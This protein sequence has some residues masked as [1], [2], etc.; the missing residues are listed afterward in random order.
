MKK[1]INKK[2]ENI[3]LDEETKKDEKKKPTAKK[4]VFATILILLAVVFV[5]LGFCLCL[6]AFD[7]LPAPCNVANAFV[8]RDS[9]GVISNQFY[10]GITF[11][12]YTVEDLNNLYGFFIN[13]NFDYNPDTCPFPFAEELNETDIKLFE[14]TL[15]DKTFEFFARTQCGEIEGVNVKGFYFYASTV[16]L[17]SDM[18]MAYA[19]PNLSSL[20]ADYEPILYCGY[21]DAF[22]TNH[23]T[24]FVF[25]ASEEYKSYI[26]QIIN[27]SWAFSS[28]SGISQNDYNQ[29]VAD[30][31]RIQQEYN[32]FMNTYNNAFSYVPIIYKSPS[33]YSV[34]VRKYIDKDTTDTIFIISEKIPISDII[35]NN[36]NLIYNIQP[37]VSGSGLWE[38]YWTMESFNDFHAF[39]FMANSTPLSYK[40][41]DKGI[42]YSYDSTYHRLIKYS[43]P[44]TF[45]T[46]KEEQLYNDIKQQHYNWGKSDAEKSKQS[47][48]D[49]IIS[50]LQSPVD[51]LKNVFSFEV[52]GINVAGVVFF[53]LSIVIVAFVVKKVV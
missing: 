31:D 30:R 3:V 25:T 44:V 11:E 20:F 23:I 10:S 27:F 2:E 38:R 35:D 26:S 36:G 4:I 42:M 13:C 41:G 46:E 17:G 6:G 8:G 48:I 18:Y 28:G 51:F 52:L 37:D 43:E 22:G 7:R 32:D 40:D 14:Y 19:T 34:L 5:V 12:N 49:G 47:T 15:D 50:V 9:V 39:L 33:D 29:L 45:A 16:E 24:N 53:I 21:F 1:N